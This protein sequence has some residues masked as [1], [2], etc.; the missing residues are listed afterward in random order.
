M[1]QLQ[2]IELSGSDYFL[3][4]MD[5]IMRNAGGPDSQ[6]RMVIKLDG[7]ID[8]EIFRNSVNCSSLLQWM[9][10]VRKAKKLPFT[11]PCWRS[12]GPGSTV[13]V[14]C[15]GGDGS[16]SE[17]NGRLLSFPRHCD[18]GATH[19]PLSFEL[20]NHDD[21]RSTCILNWDH[22]LMDAHGAE[23]LMQHVARCLEG[24]ENIETLLPSSG[25]NVASRVPASFSFAQRL[26]YARRSIHYISE[27]STM[28]IAVLKPSG[29][30]HAQ[31]DQ[32]FTIRF[33]EEETTAIISQCEAMGLSYYHSIFYL[34][35]AT[36]AVHGVR[37][38][39]TDEALPYLVPV[40]L[41]L[42][43]KG[44]TGAA[45]SN[46][47]SFL[48][49]RITPD[50]IA[51][52]KATVV[53]LKNQMKNQVMEEIPHSY[54]EMM[55]IL[56]RLPLPLYSRLLSGPTKGQFASFFFSYTGECC[57]GM[58]SFMGQPVQDVTHLAPATTI[59][60]LSVVFMR[61]RNC[62]KMILSLRDSL[63]NEK[64]LELF[65]EHLRK[66]LLPGKS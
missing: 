7:H 33:S 65:E 12:N 10:N 50:E 61:H 32:Y 30:N 54:A 26:S 37:M 57:S 20:A 41:N 24:V 22:T 43:R 9:V 56:R 13:P 28:P 45:F 31:A 4:A 19:L 46:N 64:D 66:D 55:K 27:A 14:T 38:R 23:I 11:L 47:V 25:Q 44:G 8:P 34:A 21:N 49:Y 18:Q 51:D 17:K 53:S 29:N 3:C 36:R 58:D 52:F 48:F 60:G 2:D 62:L 59:P 16:C 39:S 63:F 15:H 1:M 35:A 40:P 6:C 42:R 5:R